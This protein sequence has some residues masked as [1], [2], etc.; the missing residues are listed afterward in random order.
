VCSCCTS[1]TIFIEKIKPVNLLTSQIHL[2]FQITEMGSAMP[3]LQVILNLREEE[4]AA[5]ENPLHPYIDVCM[6][7]L[8]CIVG[9]VNWKK[10]SIIHGGDITKIATIS[11]EAMMLVALENYY[12]PWVSHLRTSMNHPPR[13]TREGHGKEASKHAG[14]NDAGRKRYNEL[15]TQVKKD[16]QADVDSGGHFTKA[17]M[18]EFDDQCAKSSR[19]RQREQEDDDISCAE[20]DF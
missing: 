13:Y 3:S 9:K 4:P 19:K 1:T 18:A 10:A 8:P 5:E 6:R 7:L 17:I 20:D 12:E 14:W 16:R 11:D 15:Y 2:L